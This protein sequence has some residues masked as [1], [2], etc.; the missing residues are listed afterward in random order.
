ML[1]IVCSPAGSCPAKIGFAGWAD[2]VTL[3]FLTQGS[4]AT[5]SLAFCSNYQ[6]IGS[7]ICSPMMIHKTTLT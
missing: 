4:A 6:K 7:Q 5:T 1:E 3:T 2:I